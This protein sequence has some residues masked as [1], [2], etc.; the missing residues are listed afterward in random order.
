MHL[1]LVS[2]HGAA[3]GK[4]AA[5]PVHSNGENKTGSR[6]ARHRFCFDFRLGSTSQMERHLVSCG[7]ML[8]PGKASGHQVLKRHATRRT[9]SHFQPLALQARLSA[10]R[11]VRTFTSSSHSRLCA[12]R[13]CVRGT[14]VLIVPWNATSRAPASCWKTGVRRAPWRADAQHHGGKRGPREALLLTFLRMQHDGECVR[15]LC[16]SCIGAS[17]I[18]IQRVVSP[19]FRIHPTWDG[20]TGAHDNFAWSSRSERRGN[21]LLPFVSRAGTALS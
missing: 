19:T 20:S 18:G 14:L 5:G 9:S 2:K 21:Y 17:S 11:N 8:G 10:V 4:R 1:R 16:P 6:L 15:R 3:G 13:A 12:R 7:D